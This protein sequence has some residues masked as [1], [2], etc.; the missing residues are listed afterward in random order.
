MSKVKESYYYTN[1]IE[2]IQKESHFYLIKFDNKKILELLFG[3]SKDV[4][5]DLKEAGET[6]ISRYNISIL[7]RLI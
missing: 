3:E 1:K 7:S 5:E 4:I 2:Y 6:A